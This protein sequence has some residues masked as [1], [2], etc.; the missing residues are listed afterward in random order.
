MK[1]ASRTV[2]TGDRR[3]PFLL[4]SHLTC[5]DSSPSP[6]SAPPHLRSSVSPVTGRDGDEGERERGEVRR[7][8]GEI[9]RPTMATSPAME[10][11]MALVWSDELQSL[12]LNEVR[13]VE[14]CHW[15]CSGSDLV[16]ICVRVFGLTPVTPARYSGG[17]SGSSGD[18]V[19]SRSRLKCESRCNSVQLRLGLTGQTWSTVASSHITVQFDVRYG[20][21]VWFSVSSQTVKLGQFWSTVSQLSGRHKFWVTSVFRTPKLAHSST[22]G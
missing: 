20:V 3:R 5:A 17:D 15:R 2:V 4:Q 11:A 1:T 22:L 10:A 8:I 9:K 21:M 18:S 16:Q 14:R 13:V 7:E 12:G 6:T 19:Q